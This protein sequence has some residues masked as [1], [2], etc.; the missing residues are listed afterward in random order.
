MPDSSKQ[1]KIYLKY[2]AFSMS[3]FKNNKISS[4][5]YRLTI[6]P[7]KTSGIRP[8]IRSYPAA[9]TIILVKISTTRLK[10]RG[11]RGSAFLNPLLGLK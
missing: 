3:L 10:N 6:P 4:A 2:F 7:G 5:Y 8:L 11:E 9:F 1:D